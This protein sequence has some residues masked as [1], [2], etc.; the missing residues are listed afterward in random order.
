MM[1]NYELLLNFLLINGE[2]CLVSAVNFNHQQIN[3]LLIDGLW[4]FHEFFFFSNFSNLPFL[5]H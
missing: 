5:Y 4:H 2:I 3:E 1:L